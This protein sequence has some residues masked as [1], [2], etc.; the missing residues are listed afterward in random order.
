MLRISAGRRTKPVQEV[1]ITYSMTKRKGDAEYE[2]T[3]TINV[4]LDNKHIEAFKS[5]TMYREQRENN[6]FVRLL[7][8][9]QGYDEATIKSVEVA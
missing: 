6:E 8:R 5:P 2:A 1:K 4:C 7:A 9:V 3:T